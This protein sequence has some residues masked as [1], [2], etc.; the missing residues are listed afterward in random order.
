MDV[1]SVESCVQTGEFY[2]TEFAPQFF[3]GPSVHSQLGITRLLGLAPS[4]P[5]VEGA[6][7]YV[8]SHCST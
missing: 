2:S 1:L 3:E 7:L 8:Q 5:S 4:H 6:G